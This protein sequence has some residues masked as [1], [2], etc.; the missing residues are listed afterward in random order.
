MPS[1]P[2]TNASYSTPTPIH[3]LMMGYKSH[4]PAPPSTTIKTK[5][6]ELFFTVPSSGSPDSDQQSL[7]SELIALD[8]ESFEIKRRKIREKRVRFASE[9]VDSDRQ[10][11]RVKSA[12]LRSGRARHPRRDGS[13]AAGLKVGDEI[14]GYDGDDEVGKSALKRSGD[15]GSAGKGGSGDGRLVGAEGKKM[16]KGRS[17]GGMFKRGEG[18]EVKKKGTEKGKTSRFQELFDWD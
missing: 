5:V 13:A 1:K 8:Q 12:K 17:M 6:D 10:T 14:G 18:E 11:A 16:K 7:L 3:D 4:P 15:R 9:T 2:P